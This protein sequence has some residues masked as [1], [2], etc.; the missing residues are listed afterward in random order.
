VSGEKG[1]LIRLLM[2]LW[3]PAYMCKPGIGLEEL[4]KIPRK[5]YQ[6]YGAE[7][8]YIYGFAHGIG[9]RFEENPITTIVLLQRKTTTWRT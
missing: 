6:S 8:S 9:L 7:K 1:E 3:N 2:R 4:E 5:V